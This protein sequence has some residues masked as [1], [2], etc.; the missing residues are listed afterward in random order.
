MRLNLKLRFIGS[1]W[2]KGW[3][4]TPV[5]VL[6]RLTNPAFA[7]DCHNVSNNARLC[8]TDSAYRLQN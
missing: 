8:E 2:V 6:F 5:C 4:L 3:L 1:W 7:T